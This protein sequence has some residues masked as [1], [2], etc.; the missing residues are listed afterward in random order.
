MKRKRVRNNKKERKQQSEGDEK[1]IPSQGSGRR[2][3]E[4]AWLDEGLMRRLRGEKDA[5]DLTKKEKDRINKR[6]KDHRWDGSD[7]WHMG[8]SGVGAKRG[9]ENVVWKLVPRPE[10]RK[11]LIEQGHNKLGHLGFSRSVFVTLKHMRRTHKWHGMRAQI[12][13]VIRGCGACER[14][15]AGLDVVDMREGEEEKDEEKQLER[16]RKPNENRAR[17]ARFM[18]LSQDVFP[19]VQPRIAACTGANAP[20]PITPADD[21]VLTFTEA[22]LP[23]DTLLPFAE[24]TLPFS[25]LM[26]STPL[27]PTLHISIPS[28]STLSTAEED[29]LH[30]T[31]STRAICQDNTVLTFTEATLP[32]DDTVL[33]FTEATLPV[34]TILPFTEPPFPVSTLPSCPT[35]LGQPML[36]SSQDVQG[37]ECTSSCLIVQTAVT[38]ATLPVPT[39]PCPTTLGQPMLDSSQ[40]V[41]GMECTSSCHIVQTAVTEA[42]LPVPT[43]PCPTTLGQPMLDSWQEDGARD[44]G[45]TSANHILQTVTEAMLPV[46]TLPSPTIMGPVL[47][48]SEDDVREMGCT[49]GSHIV[50]TVA[51]AMLPV[52]VLP[53]PAIREP[54]LDSSE[55]DVRDMGCIVASQVVQS[56]TEATLPAPTLSCF[57]TLGQPTMQSAE[58]DIQGVGC[59]PASHVVHAVAE[60][61][62]EMSKEGPVCE[63]PH[64]PGLGE[65]MAVH[66]EEVQALSLLSE[67]HLSELCPPHTLHPATTPVP[68]RRRSL[69]SQNERE[70]DPALLST[71]WSRPLIASE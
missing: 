64:L 65:A 57:S 59:S 22:T 19:R 44:G 14:A 23:Y 12:E 1:E 32:E 21:T 11:E 27:G 13:S 60:T 53:S 2:E 34:D 45:C 67:S 62:A 25:T 28:G 29:N 37:M 43:L 52:P 40:D 69:Q 15:R 58:E 38:E 30:M 3:T 50:Q 49:S 17:R 63:N 46:P 35:T 41:Q 54:A 66:R 26:D 6:A 9:K 36:D 61:L 20:K 16:K 70:S 8:C 18:L 42:T 33:P 4:D 39:L 48:S 55:A 68:Y 5:E 51:E 24:A 56:V 71:L 10:K 7:L 31:G 47:D